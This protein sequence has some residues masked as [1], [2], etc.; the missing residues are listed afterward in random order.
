MNDQDREEDP[1]C[2][3]CLLIL[4]NSPACI[5]FHGSQQRSA[6]SGATLCLETGKFKFQ[7]L[8]ERRMKLEVA[9]RSLLLIFHLRKVGTQVSQTSGFKRADW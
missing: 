9:V 7:P 4:Q 2:H 3:W 8:E 1:S 5:I 6:L